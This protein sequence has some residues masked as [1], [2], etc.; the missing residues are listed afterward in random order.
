MKRTHPILLRDSMGMAQALVKEGIDFVPM[1]ILSAHDHCALADQLAS[2]LQ[3][4][5]TMSEAEAAQATCAPIAEPTNRDRIEAI[6]QT[7]VVVHQFLTALR[8]GAVPGYQEALELMVLALVQQNNGINQQLVRL[9]ATD[10]K[11]LQPIPI[12]PAGLAGDKTVEVHF[13]TSGDGVPPGEPR[14]VV[15][16]VTEVKP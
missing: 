11:R 12:D 1:P 15:L 9:L 16:N 7:H 14:V 2:R 10:T 13:K 5:A 3:E 6:G 4:L 8:Q